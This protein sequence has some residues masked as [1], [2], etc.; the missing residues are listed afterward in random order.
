MPNQF[1][2]MGITFQYPDSWTLDQEDRLSG[3]KSVTVY[4]PTGGFWSISIHPRFTNPNALASQ[5]V[6]AMREEYP[7]VDVEEVR[8]QVLGRELVGYDLN[9]FFL[10]FT[11][12]ACIRCFQTDQGTF[13]V[14]YQAE[15]SEFEKIARV[16]EAMTASVLGGLKSLRYWD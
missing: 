13:A 15:D 14:V 10:D 11:N 6:T 9:F 2:A 5:F 7:E 8:E 4:S 1:R 12:T 3:H 16:F